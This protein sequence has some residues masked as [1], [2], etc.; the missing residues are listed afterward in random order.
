MLRHLLGGVMECEA[1]V[2]DNSDGMRGLSKAMREGMAR[3]GELGAYREGACVDAYLLASR[4]GWLMSMPESVT[5]T[6]TS[7]EPVLT[8][9]AAGMS[10]GLPV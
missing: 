3:L 9:H 10:T 7:R 8:A 5:A 1:S 2:S 6:T 4:S